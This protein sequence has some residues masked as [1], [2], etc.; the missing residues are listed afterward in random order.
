M[1]YTLHRDQAL[2]KLDIFSRQIEIAIKIAYGLGGL[3]DGAIVM[4][5][6]A[7]E[8]NLAKDPSLYQQGLVKEKFVVAWM[9]WG[10]RPSRGIVVVKSKAR[11]RSRDT[12]RF[13]CHMH[14]I[15]VSSEQGSESPFLVGQRYHRH[16]S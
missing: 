8:Q 12:T 16:N 6:K 13:T 7:E 4:V 2:I 10:C 1:L 14:S 5:R 3:V 15:R 11:S 9:A